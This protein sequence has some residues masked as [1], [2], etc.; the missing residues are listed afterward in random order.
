MSIILVQSFFFNFD[1][2]IRYNHLEWFGAGLHRIKRP[3]ELRILALF[4]HKTN[5]LQKIY[6]TVDKKNT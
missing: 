5:R 3:L 6:T 1:P 2:L 4:M